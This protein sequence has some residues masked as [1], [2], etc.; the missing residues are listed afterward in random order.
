M[1]GPATEAVASV[2]AAV[3]GPHHLG[4]KV[5]CRDY[6]TLSLN[7]SGLCNFMRTTENC[8][9]EEGFFDYLVFSFCSFNADT[10][11]IAMILLAAW[12]FILFV[13]L[14]TVADT[15]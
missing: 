9:S 11:W 2:T 10:T 7:S 12:L 15:L 14:G 13:A 6:H 8:H 4:H 3:F 1:Y 5:E